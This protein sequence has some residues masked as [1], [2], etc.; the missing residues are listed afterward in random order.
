MY[1]HATPTAT[2]SH[3]GSRGDPRHAAASGGAF[4][5]ARVGGAVGIDDREGANGIGDVLHGLR[6]EIVESRRDAGLDRAANR[7]GH[8]D[9]A[10]RRN[11]LQPRGDVHAVAVRIAVGR[12]DHVAQVHADAKAQAPVLG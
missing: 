6:A 1:L 5:T 11:R 3:D 2:T 4:G 8:D 9:A 12:L 7:L 10:G